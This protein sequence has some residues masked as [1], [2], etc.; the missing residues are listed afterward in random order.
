MKPKTEESSDVAGYIALILVAILV[1][2]T[3][4][5]VIFLIYL[6]KT[7][8]SH[9]CNFISCTFTK[10]SIDQIV[11]HTS[12]CTRNGKPI[13]CSELHEAYKRTFGDEP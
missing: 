9:S 1:L 7:S 13:N 11:E 6:W 4:G 12:E 3:I 2:S 10:S 5:E 8:D